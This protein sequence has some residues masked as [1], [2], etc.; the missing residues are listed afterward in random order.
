MERGL[1]HTIL[2]L[3]A[4]VVLSGCIEEYEAVLPEDESDILVVEGAICSSKMNTFYLTRS[5]PVNADYQSSVVTNAK[6]SVRGSD[7]SEYEALES[8]VQG[9]YICMV[10][11]LSPDVEYYLYI[12]I[13]G[14]VYESDPQKPL[15]TEKIADVRGVQNTPTSDIDIL[16]T[17]ETP[18]ESG[19]TNYYS[20]TYDETWEV[21]PEYTTDVFFNVEEM[22]YEFRPDQ[23][24]RWGWKDGRNKT[25]I[26]GSST[27][28]DHQHIQKLKIYDISNS[29][30]YLYYR[31][32]GL[33]HQRAISKA[34]Y[35]YEQARRQAGSEMG[36]LFTPLPS[37]LP[38]NIHCRT[39]GK[40]AIG[41]VGCSLNT[42]DY[43]FFL[44]ASDFTIYRPILGD[45]RTWL[46]DC[47]EV[48]CSEWVK[49]G[50]YL[51][52]WEDERMMGG[53]LRTAWALPYQLDVRLQGAYI[54][55]PEFWKLKENVSY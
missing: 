32:S 35:E 34:E 7:G 16:V 5:L 44:N 51:C 4:G 26:L 14:D 42:S 46:E 15:R 38:T 39:S 28:Y 25:I 37:S 21:H 31:Y 20:W 40:R 45:T 54:E 24:P 18:F 36:G 11:E 48:I 30:Q 1:L 2:C 49:R 47:N 29:S 52:E 53:K 41:F 23:F 9:G 43:R 10:G 19:K 33:V 27:N 55:E 6:V 13:D 17:P 8:G 3:I 22:R 50:W 12:E